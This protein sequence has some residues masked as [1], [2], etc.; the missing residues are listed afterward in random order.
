MLDRFLATMPRGNGNC[1]LSCDAHM[2]SNECVYRLSWRTDDSSFGRAR[3]AFDSV[4]IDEWCLQFEK[5]RQWVRL[6]KVVYKFDKLR[7]LELNMI[8]IS[9]LYRTGRITRWS[10]L[11]YLLS[12]MLAV[13]LGISLVYII[14][15]G[16]GAPFDNS[17]ISS[18]SSSNSTYICSLSQIS[19]FIF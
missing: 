12:M 13:A 1:S 2:L 10:L 3:A 18:C 15:P 6:V 7:G 14:R 11:Y 5:Y 8:Y 16:R 4:S 9:L 17:G 19:I